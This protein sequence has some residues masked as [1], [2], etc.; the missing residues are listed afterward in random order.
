MGEVRFVCDISCFETVSK[1]YVFVSVSVSIVASYTSSFM[2]H[3]PG[4]G[5]LFCFYNRICF[6]LAWFCCLLSL[7]FPC[8]SS[9]YVILLL[10]FCGIF[11]GE[12]CSV[13]TGLEEDLSGDS[14]PA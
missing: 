1:M 6:L 3:S 4:R 8:Y 9:S 13:M 12:G 2:V 11:Y 7:V 5:P 10:Y 14:Y